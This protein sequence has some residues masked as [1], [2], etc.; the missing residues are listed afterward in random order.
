MGRDNHPRMRQ[1]EK[2]E[3]KKANRASYDRVLIVCE[4]KKN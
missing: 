1:K 3:R 2:I 4:G